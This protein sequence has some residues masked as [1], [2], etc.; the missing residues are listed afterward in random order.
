MNLETSVTMHALVDMLTIAL[1]CACA[2]FYTPC[3]KELAD[4]LVNVYWLRCGLLLF[5]SEPDINRQQWMH[6]NVG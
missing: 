4:L 3:F 1:Q 2:S 6:I 5:G